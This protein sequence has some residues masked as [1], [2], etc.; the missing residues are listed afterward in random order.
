LNIL[1]ADEQYAKFKGEEFVL[2]IG[3]SIPVGEIVELRKSVYEQVSNILDLVKEEDGKKTIRPF[4]ILHGS[5]FLR[6]YSDEVKYKVVQVVF[7]LVAKTDCEFYRI[8][9]FLGSAPRSMDKAGARQFCMSSAYFG[10][11]T[12]LW[13]ETAPPMMIVSE[14]DREALKKL[15]YST[16]DQ[17]G[18]YYQLDEATVSVPLNKLVGHFFAKKEEL[19]CQIADLAAYV[20]L[21][22]MVGG[23]DFSRSIGKSFETIS[24]RFVVNKIIWWND[25]AKSVLGIP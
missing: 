9:Y 6:A 25:D 23:S 1:F 10:L 15:F 24:G 21:K 14:F 22:S 13:R 5:D 11:L 4:P 17:L 8:G 7:D 2:V 20:A 12:S 16:T 19:G 18:T 3:F